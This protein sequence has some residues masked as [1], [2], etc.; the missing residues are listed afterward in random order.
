MALLKVPL[1]HQ[2]F[3]LQSFFPG[4]DH[5][6]LV[7]SGKLVAA[8]ARIPASVIGDGVHTIVDLAEVE[9]RNIKRVR[10]PMKYISLDTEADRVL[11]Q[12]GY[13]RDSVPMAGARAYTRATANIST[14]GSS[15]DVT[16]LVHPD[17]ARAAVR[18]AKALQLTVA[19]VDFI[20]PD[21]SRSWHEAGGGICEVNSQV[22]LRVHNLGNPDHDVAGIILEAVYPAGDDGRIPTAMVTG[23][24]GKTTTCNMLNSILSCCGHVVGMATTDGVTIGSETMLPGDMG[25]PKGHAVALRDPTV[26]AAVL[27]TAG[28]SLLGK[29]MH[30]DQCDVAALTN[31]DHDHIGLSGIKT[32]DDMAGLNRKVLDGAR[33]AVILN[34]DDPRCL[35]MAADFTPRI[36]TILFSRDAKSAAIK[37]HLL[38]GYEAV[39]LG[40]EDGQETII[41]V[42]GSQATPVVKTLDLPSTAGG[43]SWPQSCNAMVAT[44][45]AIGL[46]I[47]QEKIIEGLIRYGRDGAA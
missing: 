37:E 33:K 42:N 3:L 9:N 39:F 21:I 2:Q 26:T 20:C 11:A 19:G 4:D 29:G 18:A 8:T 10:G 15:V 32:L 30:L 5:R 47:D 13:T 17:N 23:A 1:E 22:G 40:N 46:G 25:G 16:G 27:E 34:A 35:A 45:M 12:Q 41:A 28:R 14:G 36:R 38:L 44:A 24:M 6:L 43:I 7:V 31:V